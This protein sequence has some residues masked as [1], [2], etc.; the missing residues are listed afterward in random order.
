MLVY[1]NQT[2]NQIRVP[3]T[4]FLR[5]MEIAERNALIEANEALVHW[6]IKNKFKHI[7]SWSQNWNRETKTTDISYDDAKSAGLF[8]LVRNTHLWDASR[9]SFC[10]FAVRVIF[11]GIRRA[12]INQT[13]IRVPEP[14]QY[15]SHR[16]T[17]WFKKAKP[18][19]DVAYN[20][21]T[22]EDNQEVSEKPSSFD[23]DEI[24]QT[25]EMKNKLKY[26]ID[27]L[28]ERERQVVNGR[29]FEDITLDEIGIKLKITRERV[30]QI[31]T[32]AITKI[33]NELGSCSP[34][35]MEVRKKTKKVEE[36]VGHC[37]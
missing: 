13:V 2:K 10:T 4:A 17:K 29:F 30:R 35:P 32:V 23:L 31:E 8:A 37:A 14:V 7:R 9:G 21:T 24:V 26:A 12:I 25:S 33:R 28:T 6:T 3:F 34:R 20:V 27:S 22:I 36:K 16:N 19:I 15:K 5:G 18:F 11:T 1:H